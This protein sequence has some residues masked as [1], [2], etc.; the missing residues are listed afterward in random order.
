MIQL[1]RDNF[2]RIFAPLLCLGLC[3]VSVMSAGCTIGKTKS[4]NL[5]QP[6][7][8]KTIS[9]QQLASHL[10][11]RVGKCGS[12]LAEL[13]N[14]HN[15]VVIITEPHARV[16]VNGLLLET[17]EPIIFSNSTIIV[18]A[19]LEK[20]IR[21]HLKPNSYTPQIPLNDET[22]K[23]Q[24][25]IVVLDPGHGGKDSGAESAAG[26][27][28]KDI[29]LSVA[30]MVAQ[31]L[32]DNNVRVVMTRKKDV[33]V[34]LDRRVDIANSSRC[35]L[36]VS[37]HADAAPNKRARGFTIYVPWREKNNSPSH[38]AGKFVEQNLTGFTTD[39]GIR[40]HPTKALRV[41]E[42]TRCPAIL[43]EMGYLSNHGEA[44][45]LGTY[46]TQQKL[47]DSIATAILKYLQ[48]P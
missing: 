20:Q 29:V 39:R 27:C 13:S 3:F 43:V 17:N 9:V 26:H 21:R 40:K 14:S 10:Q 15:S 8:P 31:K 34:D 35:A 48:Q 45:R 47:A 41:L 19:S 28:E 44:G 5:N 38:R 16:L 4:E 2:S 12:Y 24:G 22:S 30:H 23:P 18:P 7:I 25:P 11:M 6:A 32:R 36:F 37:I 33:F 46:K 1:Q 42:K